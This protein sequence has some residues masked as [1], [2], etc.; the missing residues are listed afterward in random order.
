MTSSYTEL[1][2]DSYLAN[3]DYMEGLYEAYLQDPNSVSE[4]WQQYFKTLLNGSQNPEVSHFAVR[5][6]FRELARSP[7]VCQVGVSDLQASVDRLIEGFR[8]YGHYSAN[9]NPLQDAP[10]LYPA[11]QLNY[12]QLSDANLSEVFLTRGIL[13][14]EKAS[15][16][17]IQKALMATYCQ[18]VGYEYQ[19]IDDEKE[20]EWLRSQIENSASVFSKEEQKQILKELVEADGLEKYLDVRYPG[21]K[22]FSIEGADSL[23]PMLD[24]LTRQSRAKG[25]EEIGIGMAHRGRL[26]VLLNVMGQSP[27]QLFQEFDGTLDYGMTSG[28][29]KYHRG[30]SADLE[31]KDG[32]IHLSLAFNPSH[33]EF[34][35]AV[36]MG[37]TRARQERDR[38]AR[39]EDYAL[40][41]TIHGDAAFA[42]QGV[43]METLSMSQTR[44]Y[45]IGGSLHI[46]LNNQVGFTTSNIE[47]ARSSHYCSDL[48]KMIASPIFHV[49]G[50]DPESAVRIA[51]LALNYRMKFHKDVFIDLVCYRRHGHQEVDEPRATQPL[52]Y[53][54]IKAHL[55]PAELYAQFLVKQKVI[56]DNDYQKMRADY[57]QCLDEGRTIVPILS[58]ALS[59]HYSAN[60]L[61]YIDQTSLAAADTTVSLERLKQLGERLT[62]VPADFELQR[63]V[64]MIME[65]RA[66]MTRG[67]AP[68]DW[69]YAEMMAYASLLEQKI[70]VRLSG[71]DSRRGTFFHRQSTLF[72]QKTGREWSPLQHISEDQGRI[73]IYDSLL[74][75]IGALGFEYG[76][77][78]TDP[79]T[80]VLWEAQFGDFANGAQV[81]IDQFISSGCQKW[82]RLCGLTLLL[83]H[84]YEG[85]GPEHSS[86][87]LERYLQLCAQDNIQVCVP[88]TP[89]QIFHLLRRQVLRPFRKPLIIMTPKSLLRHKLA[90]SS[91]E[92]LAHGH[93]QL[94]IPEVDEV[95]EKNIRRV[96]LCSGKVYYELLE[97]RREL[98]K[99]DIAILRIEQLYPFPYTQVRE[100]LARYVNATQLVW[101]Q[102]EPRNQGAWFCTR[103]RLMRAKPEA[104]SLYY[105][106]R[107]SMAAPAAGYPALHRQQQDQL[108]QEALGEGINEEN[109]V[110]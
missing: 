83:P 56:E 99:K 91:L 17:D 88:T 38:H 35:D 13:Q 58:Q 31:T 23:I 40:A 77:A 1:K 95:E 60:W 19:H 59:H 29:V 61:K 6:E 45:K 94:V 100:Q 51:R 108:I 16:A 86:A 74:S 63:Q 103:H 30:F 26:N 5:E 68:L 76:Y 8:R 82:N 39:K 78:S 57:R 46:I 105:V 53:Q 32:P 97:K 22:R 69:G 33:L 73:A 110:D 64:G 75:E 55:P 49:N 80:L 14:N 89:S 18:S 44:A 37:S 15:L 9:M 98:Q 107:S 104:F 41:V 101:C 81:I 24:D 47:D 62:T 50:D 20:R 27:A 3:T 79:E 25:I 21:Q 34:I 102:E 43:V 72:D 106:G 48:A 85:M 12:Y 54:K 67:E 10:S 28:D 84:G 7:L 96:I 42:G 70:A 52:M 71:E 92:D 90:V 4:S 36:L 11:L 66:K 109:R 93:F 65:A 87:R 2:H